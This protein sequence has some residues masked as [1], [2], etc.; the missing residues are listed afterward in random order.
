MITSILRPLTP[1]LALISSTAI[2]YA[3]LNLSPNGASGPVIG[4]GAPIFSVPCAKAA[5]ATTANE[6][7]MPRA[8]LLELISVS[9]M[10]YLGGAIERIAA[11]DVAPLAGRLQ[12]GGG[13]RGPECPGTVERS[14]RHCGQA[15]PASA[16]RLLISRSA[17]CI[18]ST[19]AAC[20]CS[21]ARVLVARSR[22][23]L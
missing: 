10:F 21:A 12:C 4:C 7:T 13:G 16:S 18:C 11:E 5:G 19:V 1:P 22:S 3:F 8:I 23:C 17:F 20:N 2:E 9:A 15:L 6:S 14:L